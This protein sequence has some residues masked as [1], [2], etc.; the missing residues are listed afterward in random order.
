M[1]AW[2]FRTG[3]YTVL[4]SYIPIVTGPETAT[5]PASYVT[6]VRSLSGASR[7]VGIWVEVEMARRPSIASVATAPLSPI[8]VDRSVSLQPLSVLGSPSFLSFNNVR[9][10]SRSV[11]LVVPTNLGSSEEAAKMDSEADELFT[12]N[13]VV[14]VKEI[15]RRLR[16]GQPMNQC[17][18]YPHVGLLGT[19]RMR[20]KKNLG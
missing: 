15:Q 7:V 19:T 3:R 16:Y 2:L 18:K 20:N 9:F 10:P 17:S 11:S 14:Q 4:C 8:T 13:S 1:F 12:R 6:R 5:S